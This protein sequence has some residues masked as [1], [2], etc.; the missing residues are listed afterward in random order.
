MPLQ[1]GDIQIQS[2]RESS[3]PG[4]DGILTP[5]ILL[6]FTVRGQGPFMIHVLKSSFDATVAQAAVEQAAQGVIDLIDKYPK[7]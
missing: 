7:T 5:T 2:V 6:T 3:A 4:P 1:Y